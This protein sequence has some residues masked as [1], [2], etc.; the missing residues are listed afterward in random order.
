MLKKKKILGSYKESMDNIKIG[1]CFSVNSPQLQIRD[2][3]P[4]PA[5]LQA[6]HGN[7]LRIVTTGT[8]YD[9]LSS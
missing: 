8:I 6:S 5:V 9:I 7:H 3:I 2:L 4:V 1:T